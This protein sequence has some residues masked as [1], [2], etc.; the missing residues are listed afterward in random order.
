MLEEATLEKNEDCFKEDP[1]G[2][3]PSLCKAS[4]ERL[5]SPCQSLSS[6]LKDHVSLRMTHTSLLKMRKSC[7]NS[8]RTPR[9]LR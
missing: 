8:L 1:R 7:K 6:K 3:D 5:I 9:S 4:E 2:R